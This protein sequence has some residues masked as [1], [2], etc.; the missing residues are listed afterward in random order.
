LNFRLSQADVHASSELALA[1]E[2]SGQAAETPI[3][4]VGEV[5][6]GLV[7]GRKYSEEIMAYYEACAGRMP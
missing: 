4:F 5:F 1:E 6:A 3:E 2:V 7:S